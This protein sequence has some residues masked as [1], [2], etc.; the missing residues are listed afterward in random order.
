MNRSMNVNV[1]APINR[2]GYG[3]AATNFIYEMNER[4][5]DTSLWPIGGL[6]CD[7]KYVESVKKSVCRQEYYDVNAPSLKI[8]HPHDLA[9]H[10]GK[11]KHIGFP[12]FELDM[13]TKLERHNLLCQDEIFVTSKWGEQV[14]Y[15]E[16]GVKVPVRVVPLGVDTAVFSPTEV[17][18][19]PTTTFLTVGKWEVR[20]GH[21]LLCEAFSKAFTPSDDVELWLMCWN[22]FLTPPANSGKD[23]NEEW[24]K[25]FKTSPMGDKIRILPRV[26]TQKEVVDVMRAADCGVFPSRAEGWNLEL[27]ECLAVGK[28]VIAS[29]VTAHKEYCTHINAK[30]LDPQGT[31]VAHDGKWFFGQG[32]WA[33][34][35]V[36]NLVDSMRGVYD[37]NRKDG[38]QLNSA[39]IETSHK[40]S[41]INSTS[42]LVEAIRQ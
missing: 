33:A 13:F 40:F 10:V 4:G 3:V 26:Q 17:N 22:P 11:G 23:G 25:F 30:L 34:L 29:N 31:E 6:E 42:K 2:L 28:E 8:W 19:N 35:D 38:K 39:G 24:V 5:V 20:K 15:D 21:D 14:V 41:W 37:R 32:R 18:N 1:S 16:I 7:N 36:D 12:F 9:Q 27:L